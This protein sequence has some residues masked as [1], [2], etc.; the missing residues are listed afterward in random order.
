M[1]TQAKP[2]SAPKINIDEL[3][4]SFKVTNEDVF[5]AYLKE[6]WLVSILSSNQILPL[7]L[8]GPQPTQ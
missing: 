6:I 8:I 5:T 7:S 4:K 2:S 3:V 1:E